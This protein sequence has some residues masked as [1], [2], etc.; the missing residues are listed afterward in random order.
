MTQLDPSSYYSISLLSFTAKFLTKVNCAIHNVLTSFFQTV[1]VRLCSINLSPSPHC[2]NALVKVTSD[3]HLLTTFN[4]QCD[5]TN[6][7][8]RY[9]WLFSPSWLPWHSPP[10]VLSYWLL[11]A[12]PHFSDFWILQCSNQYFDLLTF[13]IYI[14]SLIVL[15]HHITLNIIYVVIISQIIPP[16]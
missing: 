11:L 16:F 1:S 6:K 8:T 3:V 5:L 7:S 9:S 4:S 12:S 2:W 10:Q 13:S 14:H 15:S